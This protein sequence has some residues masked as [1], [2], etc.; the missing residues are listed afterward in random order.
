[1]HENDWLCG[2]DCKNASRPSESSNGFMGLRSITANT[3]CSCSTLDFELF[4][5]R[6][7]CHAHDLFH[8]QWPKRVFS[9]L[10]RIG[11]HLSRGMRILQADFGLKFLCGT[12]IISFLDLG[13]TQQQANG[14]AHDRDVISWRCACFRLSLL[15]SFP[16]CQRGT[17]IA[18]RRRKFVESFTINPKCVA[19]GELYG[20]TDPNTLEWADGLLAYIV[21]K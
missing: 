11:H 5:Y 17:L 3:A 18:G 2:H 10:A 9:F 20:C 12:I 7:F 19:L 14:S 21:R 8:G 6:A 13:I 1:M 16:V 15:S 4:T